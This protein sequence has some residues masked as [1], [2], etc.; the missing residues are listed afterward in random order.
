MAPPRK[1]RCS[2]KECKDAAQRIVGDCAF[3]EGHFCGR[4]RLLEDHQCQG[5]EDVSCPAKTAWWLVG[6][7][8]LLAGDESFALDS[9]SD[10]S[11]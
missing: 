1:I 10:D 11:G 6:L 7:A 4:H 8:D 3:C 9:A 5:L 2:F